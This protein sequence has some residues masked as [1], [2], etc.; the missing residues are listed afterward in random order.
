MI[1]AKTGWASAVTPNVGW[2]VGWVERAADRCFFVTQLDLARDEDAPKRIALT[3]DVLI[4]RGF[5]PATA[6]GG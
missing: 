5:L 6:T 4:K 3:R 2:Y 1:R